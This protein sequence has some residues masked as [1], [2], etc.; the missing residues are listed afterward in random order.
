MELKETSSPRCPSSQF[1]SSDTVPLSIFFPLGLARE[2]YKL[3]LRVDKIPDQPRTSHTIDF[4]SFAGCISCQY[5]FRAQTWPA[6]HVKKT[7]YWLVIW[8]V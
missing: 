5:A 6:K 4:S 7:R 3:R 2:K 1:G 8:T